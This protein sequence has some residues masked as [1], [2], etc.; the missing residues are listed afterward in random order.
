MNSNRASGAINI[1]KNIYISKNI[2]MRERRK[3]EITADNHHAL[4]NTS[5]AIN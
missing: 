3:T 1:P 2:K 4:K 5:K